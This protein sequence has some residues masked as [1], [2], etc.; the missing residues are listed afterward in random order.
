MFLGEL[1]NFYEL[2][3]W[4]DVVLHFSS[5][6]AFG[7]IGFIILFYLNRTNKISSK[8]FWIA[9]FSFSFAVSIGVIWE[10]FEFSMDQIF[11]MHMQKSGIVDTMWDLI[12]DAIGALISVAA[13][14]AYMQGKEKSYLSKLIGLIIKEN[15]NLRL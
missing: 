14:Y 5:A 8:P 13:G 7:C 1:A 3:W 11:G 15:P 2:F 9:L 6:I 10:I 12:V 4:W